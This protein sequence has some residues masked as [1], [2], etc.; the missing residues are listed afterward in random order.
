MFTF[1]GDYKRLA[2]EAARE[3]QPVAAG[4]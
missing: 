1:D 2:A 4:W 3:G